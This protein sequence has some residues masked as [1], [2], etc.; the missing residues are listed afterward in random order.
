MNYS[1]ASATASL[2]DK[3]EAN[4]APGAQ[5]DLA[6]VK[7]M[8]V[9]S[10]LHESIE[11]IKAA[12]LVEIDSGVSGFVVDAARSRL[13]VYWHGARPNAIDREVN[14]AARSGLRI[15]VA[16]A[17]F[18]RAELGEEAER[19]VSEHMR[20]SDPQ[21]V[22]VG[23]KPDGT[24]LNVGVSSSGS[25]LTASAL[26]TKVP[27][28]LTVEEQPR[29][30]D[31]ANDVEPY[32]GG[33]YYERWNFAGTEF[34]NTCSNAFAVRSADQINYSMLT[35]A[36]CSEPGD[37]GCARNL[38]GTVMGCFYHRDRAHDVS[39][40]ATSS[41]QGRMFDGGAVNESG[42]FSKRVAGSQGNETGDMVCTSGAYSG[43]ICGIRVAEVGMTITVGGFGEVRDIVRGEQQ[44]LRAPVGNGDSGGPVF[45][46]VGSDAVNARGTITAISSNQAEWGACSGVPGVPNDQNGRHCSWKFYYPDIQASL[47]GLGTA[48][49]IG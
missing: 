17:P 15:D 10:K 29:A 38:Q 25:F 4:G 33:A 23:P 43:A 1:L 32:W 11:R 18:T 36:H 19:I 48:L 12:P 37:P 30:V 44:N 13:Q 35:A 41:A 40:Y 49:V 6:T 46:L 24:G 22:S 16:D 31:R 42:Q 39:L 34:M 20:R 26:S 7:L 14:T 21:V 27:V 2:Q 45:S 8:D 9:Q 3:T 28:D 5:V 47:R